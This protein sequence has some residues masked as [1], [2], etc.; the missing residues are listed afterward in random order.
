M[1]LVL[2]LILDISIRQARQWQTL[3]DLQ[4]IFFCQERL[5][6]ANPLFSFLEFKH[7]YFQFLSI[8]P[9]I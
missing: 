7:L 2:S 1:V 4:R 9:E 8:C 3:Q 6:K 5:T